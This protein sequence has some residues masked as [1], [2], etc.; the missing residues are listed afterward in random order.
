[1]SKGT[2]IFDLDGTL[3][4]LTHRRHHI[5]TKPKNWGAFFK[6]VSQDSPIDS[7]CNMLRNFKRDGYTIIVC[8]GRGKECFDDTIEWLR[9]HDLMDY[10]SRIFMREAKDYRP[11]DIVKQEFLDQ[12]RVEGYSIVAVVD[13][14]PRVIRMWQRNG[15]FVI[16]V[17]TGE[18]F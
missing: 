16:N 18:E 12:I 8:S 14:R 6:L 1:M 13:D 7:I 2:I 17:G 4:D 3:A 11:D 10:I 15:L 9:K 5:A